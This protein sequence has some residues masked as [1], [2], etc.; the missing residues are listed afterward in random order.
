[1]LGDG[2]ADGPT[3]TTREIL[4]WKVLGDEDG[5]G[6]ARIVILLTILADAA[7]ARAPEG[8]GRWAASYCLVQVAKH[9]LWTA[10]VVGDQA[11]SRETRRAVSRAEKATTL[12]VTE[13]MNEIQNEIAKSAAAVGSARRGVVDTSRGDTAGA[14]VDHGCGEPELVEREQAGEDIGS[15]QCRWNWP[16]RQ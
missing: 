8:L 5:A 16:D 2:H 9:A 1:M 3:T 6:A 10:R 12:A 13:V 7:I 4:S 11:V 14:D 15:G